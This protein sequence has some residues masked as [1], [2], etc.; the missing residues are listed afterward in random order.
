MNLYDL[1]SGPERNASINRFYEDLIPAVYH[2]SFPADFRLEPAGWFLPAGLIDRSKFESHEGT[3]RSLLTLDVEFLD[4]RIVELAQRREINLTKNYPCGLNCPGC[5]SE[6]STYADSDRFLRWEQ[7]F[8]VIDQAREIGLKTLKFLGPGELFQNSNLFDIL[9]AMEERRLQFSIFTKG[10][11]LGDDRLAELNFGWLGI[12]TAKELAARISRYTTLRILLGFNSFDPF[13]QDKS[14]GSLH[15]RGHYTLNNGT[16]SNRGV[17]FYTEKRNQA[18]CNLVD[19]GFNQ[20]GKQKLS[21]IAAP[22]GLDQSTEVADMYAWAAR[23]NIPLVIAPTMESGPKSVGLMKHN[24]RKDP[25]HEKLRLMYLTVY[26]RALSEGITSIDRLKKEGI[27]AYMGTAPCNQVANGLFL[28]INGQV[29]MCP[30]AHSNETIYGNIH[31][32]SISEIWRNSYNYRLGPMH[33]NWCTA[34]SNG[35]PQE[36]QSEVLAELLRDF[37]SNQGQQPELIFG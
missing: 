6:D 7:V 31:D 9:D 22:I 18:L 23:R 37:P 30:G 32:A 25:R 17:E 21:L 10:A 27:S 8:E 1:A 28:R 5:F 33:N 35:M 3:I 11:E 19:A 16:F 26:R 24:Q 13:V 4:N 36:L 12:R 14:V 2:E 15:A 34:K 29:Q 20:P